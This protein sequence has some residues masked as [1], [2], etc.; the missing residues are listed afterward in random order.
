MSKI[1]VE[2]P[3]DFPQYT[4]PQERERQYAA[5]LKL[6]ARFGIAS[7]PTIEGTKELIVRAIE[8]IG[9]DI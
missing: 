4:S 5:L 1:L 2:I 8:K 7:Q 3:S 9:V 6:Q